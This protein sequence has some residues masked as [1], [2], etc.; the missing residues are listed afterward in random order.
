MGSDV[1]DPLCTATGMPAGFSRSRSP[2]MCWITLKILTASV[3]KDRFSV[4]RGE[5][6][7]AFCY[8]IICA[9]G[10]LRRKIKPLRWVEKYCLA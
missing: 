8:V 9:T 10:T 6:S 3:F 1:V 2:M 4:R 7:G 5:V